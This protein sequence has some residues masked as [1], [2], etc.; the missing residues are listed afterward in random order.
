MKVLIPWSNSL[1]RHKEFEYCCLSFVSSPPSS[2]SFWFLPI[3]SP[4]WHLGWKKLLQFW[5]DAEGAVMG[6]TVFLYIIKTPCW[7]C[8]IT[9]IKSLSCLLMAN[10]PELLLPKY[11][12]CRCFKAKQCVR[13]MFYI[14]KLFKGAQRGW[15]QIIMNFFLTLYS[16]A[17]TI[18]YTTH[19]NGS[20]NLIYLFKA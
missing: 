11:Y 4:V 17:L 9:S 13:S 15:L 20:L 14:L 7:G 6:S 19:Q 3:C 12:C 16:G 18:K 2:S 5:A 1:R 10:T 8:C